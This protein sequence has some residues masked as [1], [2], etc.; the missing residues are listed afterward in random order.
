[1]TLVGVSVLAPTL[2]VDAGE[3]VPIEAIL[4]TRQFN[5][6]LKPIPTLLSDDP[7]G[8]VL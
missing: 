5:Q 3:G 2:D 4:S 1:M 8:R 6:L 7:L